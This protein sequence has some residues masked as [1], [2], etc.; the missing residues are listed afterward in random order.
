[1]IRIRHTHRRG[2][3]IIELM[4]SMA[5]IILIMVVISEAFSAGLHAF[6]QLKGIG[7]M[8]ERLRIAATMLRRDLQ[9]RHFEG[10]RRLSDFDPYWYDPNIGNGDGTTRGPGGRPA[11]GFFRIQTPA[12]VAGNLTY[13]RF[14]G[15][16]GDGIPSYTLDPNNINLVTLPQN[17]PV[18]HF[19]SKFVP[20]R[21]DALRLDQVFTMPVPASQ[22]PAVPQPAPLDTQEGPLDFRQLGKMNSTWA[23]I[24]WWVQPSVDP[25]TGAQQFAGTTPLYTLYRRQR[26][27]IAPRVDQVYVGVS[28]QLLGQYYGVS[29]EYDPGNY[30]AAATQL[31]FNSEYGVA[32]SP[33][34]NRAVSRSMMYQPVVNG[35]PA[36]LQNMGQWYSAPA[37]LG[38]TNNEPGTLQSD[39]VIAADVISFEIKVLRRG[40]PDFK[41][42]NDNTFLDS[43]GNFQQPY[44]GVYDTAT[45][46]VGWM[47]LNAIKIVI[48]VWDFKTSQARQVTV[49]VDL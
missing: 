7:T 13:L 19:T 1:M 28:P 33:Y 9:L 31:L 18:L 35:V 37:P 23:E 2:F 36:P 21:K 22:P 16:D 45:T 38:T 48:R 43:Q 25:L 27:M 26:L 20:E 8:Q 32:E 14:E 30:P 5:L 34:V 15:N 6:T 47:G 24:A 40:T 49:I 10:N 41:D 17:I 44:A 4:V 29:C 42:I 11:Q 12:L 3:T 46:P 39:D